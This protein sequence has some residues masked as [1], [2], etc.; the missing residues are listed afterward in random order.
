MT[1]SNFLANNLSSL[2]FD[3]SVLISLH[4]S[5]YGAQILNALPN[6]LFV[7]DM[8]AFELRHELSEANGA[9]QFIDELFESEKIK[10]LT[11]TDQ[12]Y[13]L[14]ERIVVFPPTLDDSGAGTIAVAAT[15][16]ILPVTDDHKVWMQAGKYCKGNTPA[17]TLDLLY[18][19]QVL[20][21]LGQIELIQSL[22][23]AL[24]YGHMRIPEGLCDQVVGLIGVELA[25]QCPCLPCFKTKSKE[26]LKRYY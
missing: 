12:E 11:L 8:V 14:F 22:Y 10:V 9:N 17:H 23:F 21:A 16:N 26:W 18:H 7:T 4:A 1:F 5:K 15:R 6:Q 24:H 13:E 3:T 19:P 2:I 25:L 20:T